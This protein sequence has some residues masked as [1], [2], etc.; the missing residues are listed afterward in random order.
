MNFV[1]KFGW[2]LKGDLLVLCNFHQMIQYEM[3]STY[4][5]YISHTNSGNRAISSNTKVLINSIQAMS[6][7]I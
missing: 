5:G 7:F 1:N 3:T 6:T 4:P 2:L